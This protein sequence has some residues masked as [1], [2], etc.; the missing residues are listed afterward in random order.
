MKITIY[1]ATNRGHEGARRFSPNRYGSG[2]SAD[3]MENLRFGRVGFEAD[4]G[5]VAT[6]LARHRDY[7]GP[8]DGEALQEYFAKCVRAS[9]VITAYEEA[10]PGAGAGGTSAARPPGSLSMFSDLR[11]DMQ[12][13]RDMLVLIHG[14][15]VSWEEAVATAAALEAILNRHDPEDSPNQPVRV[16]LFT[17]PS[18]GRAIPWASYRSDR[19]DAQGTAGALGRALLKVRDYL[20]TVGRE[21]LEDRVEVRDLRRKLAGAPR[22]DVDRAIAQRHVTELCGQRIHLLAHSMGNYVLQ[23][24]LARI[25]DFSPGDQMPRLFD[26]VFLCAADV[27][28]DVLEIGKPMERLHQIAQSVAV[29]HN[30]DDNALRISDFTKGNPDR[31]GQRGAAR[32]QA[33]HQKIYQID[34]TRAVSGPTQ[35]SYYTN[36]IVA[37]DIRRAIERRSPQSRNLIQLPLARNAWQLP[38]AS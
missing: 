35:H 24:A 18:D 9:Q 37:R 23:S 15:N 30:A 26:Q 19:S 17:W 36:G 6:L 12:Q 20:H 31:L 5:R 38:P 3:G 4:D 7:T 28:D 16:L 8:G 2:F 33:L 22:A 25:W 1:Y 11:T 21:I 27:D 32:P 13:G 10:P 29:Y 34:C 14:F